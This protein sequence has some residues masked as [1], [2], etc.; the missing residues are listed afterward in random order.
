MPVNKRFGPPKKKDRP[1]SIALGIGGAGRNIV[2]E[3]ASRSLSNVE[4]YEVGEDTRKPELPLISVSKKD[5]KEAFSSGLS[6][7][8]RPLTSSEKRIKEKI[9]GKDIVYLISALGGEMGS[10]TVPLISELSSELGQ[11]TIGTFATPFETESERRRKLAER[12]LE[13]SV[14][15]LKIAGIFSNE[16]LLDI[17]PH[18]PIK[19]A[20][21]VMN[22][23]IRLPIVDMNGVLTIDDMSELR[24]FC[25]KADEFRIGAGY[26]KGRKRGLVA[27]EKALDSPWLKE[28]HDYKVGL[29]IV[30][31][32]E[33]GG[34]ADA[35][36]SIERLEEE[37]PD[38]DMI[39][40]IRK[41]TSIGKRTRMTV[42]A[43]RPRQK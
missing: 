25:Q 42:L 37:W 36:D 30:T 17:N 11:F 32:G 3:I 26:G 13:E 12:S 10:W 14:N 43:G 41:D 31:N 19:K 1:S 6:I 20:F 15:H 16:R 9:G 2:T 28:V 23:I 21:K 4:V 24:Q 5:M 34:K 35:K 38:T 7:A 18:L 40:G 27:A 33:D 29:A 8:K 39:V 22:D